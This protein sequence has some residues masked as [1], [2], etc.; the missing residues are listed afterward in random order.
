MEINR[1]EIL[2]ILSKINPLGVLKN[3]VDNIPPCFTFFKDFIFVYNENFCILHPFKFGGIECSIPANEFYEVLK[4]IDE[5]EI[6]IEFKKDKFE[7][8]SKTIKANLKVLEVDLSNKISTIVKDVKEIKKWKRLPND[9]SEGISLCLLSTNKR[10][11]NSYFNCIWVNDKNMI[12]TDNYRIGRYTF[13]KGIGDSFFISENIASG[14]IKYD[15]KEY[16][17]NDAWIFFRTK[18]KVIFCLRVL[19]YDDFPEVDHLFIFDG[20]NIKLPDN[21]KKIIEVSEVL[22]TGDSEEEKEIEIK[23]ENGEITCKGSNET[24]WIEKVDE[25]DSKINLNIIINPSFMKKIIDKI[26]IGKVGKNSILFK[27]ENFEYL[28]GLMADK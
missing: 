21:M 12:S 2:E 6:D 13:D 8:K 20:K 7:I 1:K 5:D 27:I 15:M 3:A 18:N 24:G 10:L 22:A 11:T 9:F 14:L 4:K 23:I 28:I 17:K 25:I 16:Y 26:K 19:Q